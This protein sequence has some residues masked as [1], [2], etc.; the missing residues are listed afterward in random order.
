MSIARFVLKIRIHRK[1]NLYL[2]PFSYGS[3]E[4]LH[5]E[6]KS[7]PIRILTSPISFIVDPL[8]TVS[9]PF[10]NL[11]RHSVFV[12]FI[13]PVTPRTIVSPRLTKEAL[14]KK[15]INKA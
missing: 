5:V 4:N 7:I 8:R 14:E 6:S 11:T 2:K 10:G 13:F 3:D 12:D 15:R 9:C 1:V